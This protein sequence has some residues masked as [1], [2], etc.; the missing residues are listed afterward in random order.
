MNKTGS[1][2]WINKGTE[3]Q[4]NEQIVEVNM[5]PVVYFLVDQ[6]LTRKKGKKTSEKQ[7]NKQCEPRKKHVHKKNK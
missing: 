1:D 6:N 3:K 7:A 5:Q 4:K 2:K